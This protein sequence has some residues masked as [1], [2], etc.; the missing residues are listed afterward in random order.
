MSIEQYAI[1][2]DI[3]FPFESQAY[4]VAI[5]EMRKWDNL[6]AIY[7]NGDVAEIQSLS[8]HPKSPKEVQ[9]LIDE[10]DYVNQKFD[11]LQNLFPGVPVYYIEGNHE[12]RIY[13]YL[14][15]VAPSLWG[16]LSAPN[17][18][19][20][21]ERPGWLFF[22][23]GPNQL[24]KVGKTKDLYARHEPVSSGVNCAKQTAE[25]YYVSVIFGHTHVYQTYTVKKMGPAPYNVTAWSNGFMGDISNPC[26]N[27]RSP[28]ENWQ[29]GYMRIDC[30]SRTGAYECRFR[31]FY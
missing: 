20:F 27:Y 9:L 11:T 12:Y 5:D 28:K 4:Y 30:E 18:F 8:R 13:R 10:L 31:P 17:L 1:L 22:D 29:L 24:V 6:K 15:D 25:K 23:Y 3:H 14:R 26:F 7:L 21:P 19:K 2:N 16:M